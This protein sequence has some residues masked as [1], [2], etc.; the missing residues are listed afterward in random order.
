M[1]YCSK[2]EDFIAIKL[3]AI[4]MILLSNMCS[5]YFVLLRKKHYAV[6]FLSKE[7]LI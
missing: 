4:Q 3:V 1:F 6:F 5:F 2:V 7:S